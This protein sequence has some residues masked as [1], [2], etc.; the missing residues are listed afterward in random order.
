M[1]TK[2]SERNQHATAIAW[3]LKHHDLRLKTGR[4][5]QCSCGWVKDVEWSSSDDLLYEAWGQHLEELGLC[6]DGW[7]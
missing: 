5:A 6:L 3:L 4:V 2:Y 1:N 7:G